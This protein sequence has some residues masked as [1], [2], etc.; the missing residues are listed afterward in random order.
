VMEVNEVNRAYWEE[1]NC[2]LAPCRS[3]KGG[4][5]SSLAPQKSPSLSRQSREIETFLFIFSLYA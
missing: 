3:S 2:I 4:V 5:A 1:K